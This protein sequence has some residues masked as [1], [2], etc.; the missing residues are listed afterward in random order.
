[1]VSDATESMDG[2]RKRD[3]SFVY[4]NAGG[5]CLSAVTAM[6]R[7]TID[8]KKFKICLFVVSLR[9]FNTTRSLVPGIRY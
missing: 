4:L 7:I 6:I 9:H 1:M 5:G 3:K 8:W 2:R